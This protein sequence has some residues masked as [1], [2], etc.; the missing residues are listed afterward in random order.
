MWLAGWSFRH[1]R[2]AMYETLAEALS[3]K[4]S[5]SKVT[6]RVR[7]QKWAQRDK[8]RNDLRAHVYAHVERRL[9]QGGAHLGEALRPFVPV[10]EHLI[11]STAD[12]SGDL[13]QAVDLVI[14]N[15]VATKTMNDAVRGAMAQPM[16]GVASILAMSIWYG[17]SMW[18]EFMRSIPRRFWP[19]W[20]LPCIDVQTWVAH[21]WWALLSLFVIAA[22]YYVTL[23]TWTGRIRSWVDRIPPWSIYRGRQASNLLCVLS[24]LVA[25]GVTVRE[26]LV[27]VQGYSTPYMKWHLARIINRYDSSGQDSLASLRTGLFSREI[28]DRVED[29]AANRTFD[30][31]LR[32]VGEVSLNM[33]VRIVNAQAAAANITFLIM[34]G[35][36]FTYSATVAVV[37]VQEAVDAYM[38]SMGGNAL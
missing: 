27:L 14:R 16:L 10:D 19:T 35:I 2:L 15:I 12:R 23:N 34:V 31:T 30:A 18:P 25:C 32:H 8:A 36:A 7:F 28:L 1:N 24:A 22:A 38:K 9:G 20:A 21:H 4:T 33:V 11:L 37:G 17:L 13:R 5:N 29:A 6:L 26:A 3:E